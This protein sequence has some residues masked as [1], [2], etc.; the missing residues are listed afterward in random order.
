VTPAVRDNQRQ[1]V[2]LL[3]RTSDVG[4]ASMTGAQALGSRLGARMI[5]SPGT[6]SRAHWEEDLSASRGVLL[7]AGG[8]V[9]DA[10]EA[11]LMP[12]LVAGS[13]SI[14]VSTLPVVAR[15]RPEAW[16]LWLD[17][18]GD[19]N[20]PETTR[21]HFLGGMC[22]SA[23]CGLWDS[24]FGAGVDPSRVV[25]YGVRDVD[26]QEQVLL[27]TS[28]VGLID[29]P[30]ELADAL[31]GRQVYVHLDLDVLDPS[32]MPADFP[33]AGGMDFEQLRRLLDLVAGAADVIG[34]EITSAHPD[35]A[36]EIAAAVAPLL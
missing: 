21:S 3:P 13:C 8:Q 11:G 12:L 14:C 30:A 29:R 9:D 35:R 15:A 18:H 16:V 10:F 31:D 5:G 4:I 28:G 1:V 23:A 24:G 7:E 27:E 32:V 26:G 20:T 36:D 34:A 2:A 17:A 25:M 6:G 19:F 33:V 22:L